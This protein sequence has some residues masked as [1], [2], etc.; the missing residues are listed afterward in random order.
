MKKFAAFDIDGTLIRWQLYH[1]VSSAL[2][3]ESTDSALYEAVRLARMNWKRRSHP[4]SFRQYEQTLIDAYDSVVMGLTVDRFNAVVDQVFD[5]YRDQVY[6][7]TRDQVVQ[8]KKQGYF[9]LAISGSQTEMVAKIANYYGFDDYVGTHFLSKSGRFTGEK[10]VAS[11]NKQKVLQ[12]LIQK[13]SLGL[14][15]SI[16]IGDSESD[17]AMLAMVENP[18]AFNPTAELFN[19]AKKADWEVVVERKNMVYTL[20]A[21]DGSYILA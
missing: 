11:H 21:S 13:H 15:G 19:H 18:I 2:L 20:E 14:A 12:Q 16:A 4:Q 5:E 6:T 1:A 3:R 7:Y 9:L 17:I 10:K 8:L